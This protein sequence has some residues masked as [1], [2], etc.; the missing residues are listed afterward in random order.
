MLNPQ[1]LFYA[2]DALQEGP[3]KFEAFLKQHFSGVEKIIVVDVHTGLGKFGEDVLLVDA[4]PQA[5]RKMRQVFGDRVRTLAGSG[6]AYEA[7]GSQQD[8]YM[9]TFP[10]AELYFVTQEFGTYSGL[11]VLE[12]LRSEN[13]YHTST[14]DIRVKAPPKM[15]LREA[16]SPNDFQWRKAVLARGKA[17]FHQAFALTMGQVPGSNL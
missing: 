11:R 9:R 17:V 12:A 2:G 10:G 3:A 4:D 8:L 6:I 7:T 5:T 13:L 16:F 14:S 15:A 1:G